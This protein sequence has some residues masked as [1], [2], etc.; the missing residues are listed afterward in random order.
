M[1]RKKINEKGVVFIV[2]GNKELSKMIHFIIK[3]KKL[4][5][6]AEAFRF[7]TKYFYHDE[8]TRTGINQQKDT[9]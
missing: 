3:A 8:L 1:S 9:D 4:K 5:S 7:A 6:R 2:R